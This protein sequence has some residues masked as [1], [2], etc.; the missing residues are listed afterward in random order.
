[1]AIQGFG[2]VGSHAAKIAHDLGYKVV[3]VSDVSGGYFNGDGLDIDDVLA[4]TATS[5]HHLLKGYPHA[6]PISNAELLALD[7]DVLAPCALENQITGDNADQV[8]AF[9]IVEG[10]NGPTTPEA[11]DILNRKGVEIIPDILANAGGVTVSYFEWVQGLQSFF[12]D[13][14][15]VNR[16]LRRVLIRAYDEVA[17]V[18]HQYGVD[19]RT[20]AQITAIKRVG[21]AT[22]TRGIYP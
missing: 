13:I 12:W 19:M 5:E 16:Q 10:A 2:N 3:A 21:E 6:D 8:K 11:D 20:A 1:M 17:R 15:E 14:D 9:L 18:R 4:Y 22:L 7:C